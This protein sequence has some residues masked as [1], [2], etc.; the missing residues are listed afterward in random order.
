MDGQN[1]RKLYTPSAKYA[2]GGGGGG[3]WGGWGGGGGGKVVLTLKNGFNFTSENKIY[4]K[5]LLE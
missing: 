2:W 5:G 1:S 3:G 4:F